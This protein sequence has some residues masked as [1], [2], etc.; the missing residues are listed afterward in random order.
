MGLHSTTSQVENRL[1][2]PHGGRQHLERD[3]AHLSGQGTW[4]HHGSPCDSTFPHFFSFFFTHPI[5]GVQ[6]FFPLQ[7]R[8]VSILYMLHI[9]R[10]ERNWDVPTTPIPAL[11]PATPPADSGCSWVGCIHLG[12]AV[13]ISYRKFPRPLPLRMPMPI[14]K[15]VAGVPLSTPQAVVLCRPPAVP[16]QHRDFMLPISPV[17]FSKAKSPSISY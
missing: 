2:Q 13:S 17:F 1:G 11:F 9:D 6:S 14:G 7:L 12:V 3:V 15:A 10:T 5:R 8:S 16:Q 4:Q